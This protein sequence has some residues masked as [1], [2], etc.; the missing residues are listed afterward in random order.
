MKTIHQINDKHSFRTYAAPI[1]DLRTCQEI[2]EIAKNEQET[3]DLAQHT[4]HFS[5]SNQPTKAF[6]SHP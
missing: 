3:H 6:N 2:S 1:P 4:P 5:N